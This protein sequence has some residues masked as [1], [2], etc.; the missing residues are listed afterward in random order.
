MDQYKY[1]RAATRDYKERIREICRET[2]QT[3]Y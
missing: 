2:G 3:H 1:F